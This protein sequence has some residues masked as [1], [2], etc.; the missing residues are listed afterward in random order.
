MYVV[1]QTPSCQQT[2]GMENF[3]NREVNVSCEKCGGVVVDAEGRGNL[4]QHATVITGLRKRGEKDKEVKFEATDSMTKDHKL[5]VKKMP[6]Y[7]RFVISNDWS[8]DK[9]FQLDY[10]DKKRLIEFLGGT[11]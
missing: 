7:S 1:C 8:E 9:T 10:N 4:S 2:Y 6:E 11:I 5:V 3:A